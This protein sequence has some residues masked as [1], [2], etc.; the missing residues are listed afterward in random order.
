MARESPCTSLTRQPR[1]GSKGTSK[2]GEGPEIISRRHGPVAPLWSSQRPR[3]LRPA[4]RRTG[5]LAGCWGGNS[6]VELGG[7]RGFPETHYRG[8]NPAMG[9]PP[10]RK[11][12]PEMDRALPQAR[13][14]GLVGPSRLLAAHVAGSYWR[15]R[16]ARRP[17]AV[18]GQFC[19][20][21]FSGCEVVEFL[22][23]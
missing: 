5:R 14:H 3:C 8:L 13:W 7:R 12:P 11:T 18:V 21:G 22:L 16:Y 9:S 20:G 2:L 6:E 23:V 17:L 19:L 10:P 4:V 15:R 1:D